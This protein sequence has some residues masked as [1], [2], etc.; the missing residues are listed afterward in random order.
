[1]FFIWHEAAMLWVPSGPLQPCV[2]WEAKG[3]KRLELSLAQ[4][5]RELRR[6]QRDGH[7]KTNGGKHLMFASRIE[8]KPCVVSAKLLITHPYSAAAVT[9][10]AHGRCQVVVCVNMWRRRASIESHGQEG[11]VHTSGSSVCQ[12]ET[13][14]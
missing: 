4:L 11:H 7:S 9:A 14:L 10:Q 8:Q 3:A 6:V 1:M 13:S 5:A 12:L 2:Y